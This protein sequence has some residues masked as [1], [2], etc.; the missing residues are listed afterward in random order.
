MTVCINPKNL[1][2]IIVVETQLPKQWN[3]KF[4]EFTTLKV[5]IIKSKTA[6]SLPKAD[7]YIYKYS[8]IAG[9]IDIFTT[10]FFKTVIYDEVQ[11]LRT[12]TASDKGIAAKVLSEHAN[13][14]MGMSHTPIF[15]YALEVWNIYDILAPGALGSKDEF[16]RE[17]SDGVYNNE[18]KL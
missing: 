6:Y 2:A 1:P 18:I 15:G 12:G 7:V 13:L 14:N 3:D 9:W 5:H 10:G 16:I 8:S 11:N 4:K 17:W